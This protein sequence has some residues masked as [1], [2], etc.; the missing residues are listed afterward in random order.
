MSIEETIKEIKDYFN[1]DLNEN[2]YERLYWLLAGVERIIVKIESKVESIKVEEKKY[3]FSAADEFE[4]IA[5]LHGLTTYQMRT[6]SRRPD[7][8]SA[9]T[10]FVRS[11]KLQNPKISTKRLAIMVNLISHASVLNMLYSS[12]ITCEI[13]PFYNP[14]WN[15]KKGIRRKK[16]AA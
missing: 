1:I 3:E 2:G 6:R 11:C 10:H 5:E 7:L 16:Q 14:T 9:R 4:R 15:L 12:K 13:P 8:V